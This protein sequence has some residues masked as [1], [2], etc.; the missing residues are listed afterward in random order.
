MSNHKLKFE[1]KPLVN[2]VPQAD[3]SFYSGQQPTYDG[4]FIGYVL[5]PKREFIMEGV[6]TLDRQFGKFIRNGYGRF[7]CSNFIFEGQYKADF[8]FGQGREI[9]ADGSVE[10]GC[11]HDEECFSEAAN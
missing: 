3:G 1:E 9:S 4:S 2:E 5:H 11:W 8:R 7:I 6:F 10:Q